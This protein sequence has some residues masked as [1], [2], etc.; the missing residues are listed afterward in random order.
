MTKKQMIEE[1]QKA[2]ATAWRDLKVAESTF[3]KAA[4]LT[5]IRRAHWCTLYDLRKKTLGLDAMPMHQLIAE[6]LLPLKH[7]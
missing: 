1:I 5:S 3:G 2:E 7:I 4:E 6:G